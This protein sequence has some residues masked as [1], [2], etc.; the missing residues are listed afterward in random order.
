MFELSAIAMGTYKVIFNGM[1][2]KTR[3]SNTFINK[4]IVRILR[5]KTCE[6]I[7]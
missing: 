5:I 6:S 1:K 2:T 4:L 7:T 3:F